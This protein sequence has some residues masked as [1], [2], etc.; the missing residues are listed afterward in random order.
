[1]V[2][3]TQGPVVQRAQPSE[4]KD[5]RGPKRGLDSRWERPRQAVANSPAARY[6]LFGVLRR[7]TASTGSHVGLSSKV[8]ERRQAA[9]RTWEVCCKGHW[10]DGEASEGTH[11]GQGREGRQRCC[12]E[13]ASSGAGIADENQSTRAGEARNRDVRHGAAPGGRPRSRHGPRQ[14]EPPG[15]PRSSARKEQVKADAGDSTVRYASSRSHRPPR[16]LQ[17]F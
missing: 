16:R 17:M 5:P 12:C 2:S 7:A 11:K 6:R 3:R 8:T 4:P 1:M 13:G 10:R 9:T 14:T 15:H